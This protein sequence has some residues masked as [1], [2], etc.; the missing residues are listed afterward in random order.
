MHFM[1]FDI[2]LLMSSFRHIIIDCDVGV[3][4]ICRFIALVIWIY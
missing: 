2:L 3:L 1:M 4:N